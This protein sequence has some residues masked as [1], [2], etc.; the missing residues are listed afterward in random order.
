M[1]RMLVTGGAGFIGK[2][3]IRTLQQKGNAPVIVDNLKRSVKPDLADFKQG[4]VRDRE[5]MDSACH[6]VDTVFHL[7][8][9]SSVLRAIA[10]PGYSFT[11]NVGG[12]L[13][14]LE[15]ARNAGVR[16]V[17][18]TSSREVYGDVQLLPVAE[19]TRLNPKNAYGA[20]KAAAEMYCSIF[21]D[22][23]VV[24]LRLANVYG[25]GDSDR[26]VPLFV[27]AAL[28]GRPIVVFGQNKILDLVWIED[29]VDA[30]WKASQ[31]PVAGE[32]LNIGAGGS[33]R[34]QDLAGRIISLTG[35]SS[36]VVLAPE[37]GG[38]VDRYCAE[39]KRAQRLLGYSPN[40]QPLY[41]LDQ[42]VQQIDAGM[43]SKSRSSD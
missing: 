38:E 1:G 4:D 2:H 42:I 9:Q 15:A 34:L 14:V 20:N 22:L 29:A 17:V 39:I 7:A 6:D 26:V 13:T 12:T 32:T 30:L 3:L 8:A 43:L 37:R 10:E 31:L 23:E 27:S 19:D 40:L 41:G 18:F 5:F 21:P 36:E 16:R 28:Q 24:I 25:P 35:S 33:I 11:T